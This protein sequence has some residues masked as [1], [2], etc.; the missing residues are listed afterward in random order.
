VFGELA[1]EEIA[2]IDEGLAAYLGLSRRFS[3]ADA[4]PVQ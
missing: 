1:A 3:G 4:V 2:A